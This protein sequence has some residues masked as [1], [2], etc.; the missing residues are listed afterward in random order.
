[1]SLRRQSDSYRRVRLK[2]TPPYKIDIGCGIKCVAGCL[3][4][5]VHD[6]G[7]AIVWDVLEGI[8]LPDNSVEEVHMYHFLEHIEYFALDAFF[9]EIRR[10]C[11]PNT[12]VHIR[13]PH[14]QHPDAYS[15]P[16]VSFWDEKAIE[17]MVG[18]F[19]NSRQEKIPLFKVDWI[20][21]KDNGR[22]LCCR[23]E[24]LR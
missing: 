13:V 10:V 11:T 15:A 3:G 24:I 9:R 22:L 4:I 23:I 1:M 19:V 21:T 7:Q 20:N 16:H 2:G 6:N 5:D 12:L 17:G 8:P 18:G 14:R